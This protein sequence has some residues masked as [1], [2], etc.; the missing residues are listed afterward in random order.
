MAG[1]RAGTWEQVE[2]IVS[3]K[4]HNYLAAEFPEE[5]EPEI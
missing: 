4:Q 5:R 1:L 2:E 3:E